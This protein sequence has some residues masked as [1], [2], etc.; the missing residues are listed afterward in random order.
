MARVEIDFNAEVAFRTE[1]AVRI[2]DINY[3][4]HLGHDC[5]VSMLHEVRMQ[6]FQHFGL[7]EYDVAGSQVIVADLAVSYRAE[8][9]YGQM[10]AVEIG[11]ESIVGKGCE[12]LYRV[13][14]TQQGTLVALAKT[15]LVFFD[16]KVKSLVTVPEV[17]QQALAG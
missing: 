1:L 3:G 16:P 9:F 4:R 2:T 5:L 8:A 7:Q 12:M 11:V 13:T 14:E 15:G 17:L 6:F 10:L